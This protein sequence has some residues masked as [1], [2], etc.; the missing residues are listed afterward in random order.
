[1]SVGCAI[2]REPPLPGRSSETT[3]SSPARGRGRG[4][5]RRLRMVGANSMVVVRGSAER[6]L[7]A[8][9][10]IVSERWKGFGPVEGMEVLARCTG[11][12]ERC[13]RKAW[14]LPQKERACKKE[15]LAEK[16]DDR[17]SQKRMKTAHPYCSKKLKEKKRGNMTN[18]CCASQRESYRSGGRGLSLP[19]GKRG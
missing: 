6:L 11:E 19:K 9:K 12:R 15:F 4:R 5:G 8:S 18:H 16:G 10:C 14:Q 7:R 2:E 17:R 3:S 13:K 1:M